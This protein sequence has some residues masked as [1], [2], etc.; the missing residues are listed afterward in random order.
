MQ[1]KFKGHRN[2]KHRLSAVALPAG[3]GQMSGGR[4]G[5]R[6]LTDPVSETR[7]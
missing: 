3:A 5:L 2:D 1:K 7:W 4:G 6:T